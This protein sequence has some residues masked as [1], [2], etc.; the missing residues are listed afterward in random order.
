[1]DAAQNVLGK[2]LP[3]VGF[4]T[5]GEIG[6]IDKRIKKLQAARYHNQTTVILV[7]GEKK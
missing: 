6:P 2:T 7:I 3:M 4:F 1:V 5:Y